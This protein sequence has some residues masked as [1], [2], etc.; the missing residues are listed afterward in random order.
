VPGGEETDGES[1]VPLLAGGS[2]AEF[3][4]DLPLLATRT[5]ISSCLIH[6]GVKYIRNRDDDPWLIRRKV[7]PPPEGELYRLVDDPRESVNLATAEPALLHRLAGLLD[8][9]MTR[10][11]P[12]LDGEAVPHGPTDPG[13]ARQLR[14]LGY[15]D[16][17]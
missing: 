5:D 2:P 7:P 12:P 9:A 17:D 13:L 10:A 8:E 6:G 11:L 4:R 15:V 16:G 1:L 3:H 14:A